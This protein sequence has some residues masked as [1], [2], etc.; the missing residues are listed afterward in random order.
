[1][2]FND[3]CNLISE[4]SDVSPDRIDTSSQLNSD[5]GLCSYDIMTLIAMVEAK[6]NKQIDITELNGQITVGY[7]FEYIKK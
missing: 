6:T 2:N 5:L 4:L 1:M 7:L 3:L